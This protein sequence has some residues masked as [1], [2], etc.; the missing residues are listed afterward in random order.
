MALWTSSLDTAWCDLPYR[1]AYVALLQDL[2]TW[3]S[4]PRLLAGSLVPGE[5]WTVVVPRSEETRAPARGWKVQLPDGNRTEAELFAGAGE[6]AA[7]GVLQVDRLER[8]GVY[9]L[10]REGAADAGGMSA[11]ETAAVS[12]DVRESNPAVWSEA[13]LRDLFPAGRLD[14]VAAGDSLDGPALFEANGREI[15]PGLA[16]LLAAVL[17]VETLLAYR[18]SYQK[19]APREG[20]RPHLASHSGRGE[21]GT[22]PSEG[23]AA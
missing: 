11:L 12:V 2:F 5:T 14:K 4:M 10:I 20:V 8:P 22:G 7:A 23:A 21:T 1:P 9:H 13:Q 18:F 6:G 19:A 3:L 15:W 17:L 16:A